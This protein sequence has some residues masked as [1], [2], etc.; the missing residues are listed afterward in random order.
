[1]GYEDDPS[2]EDIEECGCPCPP[3][4]PCQGCAEYWD[5]M[6]HEGY[7][8]DATGWTDKGMREMTK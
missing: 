8:K 6:R 4:I 7:W 1:M 3:D 2:M 5:R